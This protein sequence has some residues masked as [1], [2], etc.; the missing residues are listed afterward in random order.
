MKDLNYSSEQYLDCRL[1]MILDPERAEALN[2]VAWFQAR[3]PDDASFKPEQAL[4]SAQKAVALEPSNW[5]YLNTLGVAAFRVGDWKTAEKSLRES[6][7]FN[8]GRAEDWFFLAMTRWR[9]GEC[10]EA[11]RWFDQAVSWVSRNKSSYEL[12]RFH[13]EA[14]ALLG[15]PEPDSKQSTRKIEKSKRITPEEGA[16]A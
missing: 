15:L 1:T 5:L 16:P 4:I 9:Q 10:Q 14:A 2:T 6:I 7:G 12:R 8:G 13:A 3:F 11:R